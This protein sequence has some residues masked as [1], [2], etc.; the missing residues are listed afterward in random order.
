MCKISSVSQIVYYIYLVIWIGLPILYLITFKLYKAKHKD[1][2][3]AL[4]IAFIF[5]VILS[6]PKVI[7]FIYY[8]SCYNCY[9]NNICDEESDDKPVMKEE[10]TKNTSTSTS[11]TTT[12]TTTKT[13]TK[14]TY[15]AGEYAPVNEPSGEKVVIGKSS[16]GYDIYTINGVTYVNGILIANKTYS[17]PENYEPDNTYKSTKGVTTHCAE[18]INKQAYEAFNAMKADAAAVNITLWIQSGY[19]PYALQVKLYNNYV[20]RDGKEEADTYSSRPGHSEHQSSLCF[21][22]NNP[23]RNFNGTTEANW[24]ANNCYKYGF[25]IR[26]PEGKDDETGYTYES[27]HVRYVGTDLSYKLYNDGDWITLESYLGITSKYEE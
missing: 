27:W 26:Y 15:V 12:T 18:C 11:T 23:S 5:F 21:D 13:T 24:I 6:L 9:I 25:I 8:D 3:R 2:K 16:K 17:L 10:T 22:I 19:R 1:Y 4:F 20:S 14:R 7:G